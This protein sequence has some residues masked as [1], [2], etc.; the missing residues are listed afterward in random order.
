MTYSPLL[1]SLF[2]ETDET[3]YDIVEKHLA[4]GQYPDFTSSYGETPLKQAFR[5]AR[6][7]VFSLLLDHGADLSHMLWG[8]LHKAV[9]LGSLEEV[10]SAARDRDMSARDVSGLTPIL[11]ACDI[12]DIEKAATLLP[13]SKTDDRFRTHH[14][15]PALMVAAQKGRAGIVRW[16]LANG[17]DVNEPDDFGGTALIAAAETNNVEI[18]KILLE[19]SADIV[20]RFDLSASVKNIDYSRLDLKPFPQDP[21]Q[22]ERQSF[23][24][25]ASET[26]S[27]GVARLLIEAGAKP[28]EFEN[29]VLRDLT[30]AALIQKQQITPAMYE[31]QK[32]RRFGT[33][34]PEPVAYEFW[35][36]MVRSGESGYC[37]HTS[38]G[39][40]A[41]DFDAPAIWCF[42]RFG[43]S[44][45]ELP[46]NIWVQI[47]GEHEDYYD[48]DFCI[49]NDVVV[50]DGE[51]NT[52][53][54]NY[55]CEVF[56]PTDFHT[57]T[58]V[59]DNIIVV[60]SL[61]YQGDRQ[62][63]QTQVLRLNLK[64]FSIDKIE[65]SGE[66][67]GWISRHQAQLDGEKITVWGGDVWDGSNLVPMDG[68][69]DF[70][71]ET[72]VWQKSDRQD[73]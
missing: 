57:A 51:G 30:G 10:Q 37:G 38:F 59:N 17:F 48:P 73:Y 61:G 29:Y 4:N 26:G 1:R 41:R 60:G 16:L 67:P 9:A 24:T 7:D 66:L 68:A 49:Y 13:M 20:A 72:G 47:A 12:G 42:D 5:R 45:T 58:L 6:M 3:L 18:V 8:P 31:A 55:P 69:Y 70:F 56:P 34:N 22:P 25:A 28:H 21:N 46:N 14:R 2:E 27:A 52:Q 40:G 64:D 32:N 15:E 63:D 19:A 11:L 62:V 33:K 65:I 43:M 50:H 39:K 71:W 23:Q 44:T 53:I 36:E 35:L 54:Y